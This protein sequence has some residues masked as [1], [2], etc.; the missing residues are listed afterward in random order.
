[1]QNEVKLGWGD[2]VSIATFVHDLGIDKKGLESSS[3]CLISV[4]FGST[5]TV[6][7]MPYK[8][9]GR[10]FASARQTPSPN[11]C[12]R[13]WVCAETSI[14][15]RL[16]LNETKTDPNAAKKS[17][18]KISRWIKASV[19]IFNS[20]SDSYIVLRLELRLRLVLA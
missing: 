20:S 16:L 7:P 5:R 18:R 17:D 9:R 10:V 8:S 2:G 13:L 14:Y 19:A 6:K 12:H 1:M 15:I 4:W 3:S 11:I